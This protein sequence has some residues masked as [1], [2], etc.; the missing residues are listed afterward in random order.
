MTEV[1]ENF[2]KT[3]DDTAMTEMTFSYLFI[4]EINETVKVTVS[5]KLV[6]IFVPLFQLHLLP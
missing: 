5:C 1:S 4:F 3:L 6:L 2:Q